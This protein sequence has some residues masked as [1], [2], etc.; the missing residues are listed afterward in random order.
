MWLIGLVLFG[1]LAVCVYLVAMIVVVRINGRCPRCGVR[2][3]A[4]E[5]NS[6]KTGRGPNGPFLLECYRCGE[7]GGQFRRL[8]RGGLITK[9]AWDAGAREPLPTATAKL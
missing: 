6:V 8:N 2:R 7:C 3:L 4:I 9:E 5:P 1:L